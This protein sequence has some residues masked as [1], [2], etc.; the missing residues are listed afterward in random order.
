M[1]N[2]IKEGQYQRYEIINKERILVTEGNFVNGKKKW[3]I[4]KKGSV[5]TL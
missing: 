5:N 4:Q 3:Y 1:I 2:G